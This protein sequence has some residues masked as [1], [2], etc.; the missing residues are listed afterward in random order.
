MRYLNFIEIAIFTIATALV[1]AGSSTNPSPAYFPTTN[2][3]ISTPEQQG[4]DSEQLAKLFDF[5]KENDIKLSQSA[6][7]SERLSCSGSIFLSQFK[8]SCP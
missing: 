7:S 4:I 6:A 3:K 8:R 1:V 2:W 5:V